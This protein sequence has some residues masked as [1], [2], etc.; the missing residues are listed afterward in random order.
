MAAL[1]RATVAP[2]YCARREGKLFGAPWAAAIPLMLIQLCQ[3]PV[4]RGTGP[5]LRRQHLAASRRSRPRRDWVTMLRFSP[6][7]TWTYPAPNPQTTN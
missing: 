2:A 7:P 3:F 1:Q 6:E 4:P 5:V